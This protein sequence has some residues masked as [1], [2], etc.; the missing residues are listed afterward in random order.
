MYF[1]NKYFI[2]FVV[3]L[4]LSACGRGD[5]SDIVSNPP[6]VTTTPV[7]MSPVTASCVNPHSADY[8]ESYKC[9]FE[10]PSPR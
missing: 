9:K 8:P 7:A 3:I 6:P 10:T 4:F 5:S 2:Q 1:S